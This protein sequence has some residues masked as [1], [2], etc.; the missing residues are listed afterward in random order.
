MNGFAWTTSFIIMVLSMV[1]VSKIGVVNLSW[2]ELSCL[3]LKKFSYA[4]ECQ[5]NDNQSY[6]LWNIRA[7]R[8]ILSCLVGASLAYCGAS[9]QGFFRNSLADPGIIGIT[10]GATLAASTAIVVFSLLI[11]NIPAFI[12][13]YS[14]SFAAFIG[15]ALATMIVM[16]ISHSKRGTQIAI[17]LLSGIAI[18]ALA[19]AISGILVYVADDVQLRSIT[20]W[21]LGSIAGASWQIVG[22]VAIGLAIAIILIT[23]MSKALNAIALGEKEMEYLGFSFKEVKYKVIIGTALATGTAVAFCGA[24]GFVGLV[25]PH[26]IRVAGI[27]N[28]KT[29]MPLS[30]LFGG[31]LLIWADTISRTIV[32]PSELPI[33]IITSLLG[34]PVFLFLLLRQKRQI[35]L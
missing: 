27:E 3:F 16:A 4:T 2:Q 5:V 6:I 23:P 24:I 32:L 34:A 17:L 12:K 19:G 31:I 28:Y 13:D 11:D 7:P 29:L 25:V 30:A 1:Y 18:N 9:L 10:G 33:G 26:I 22:I 20:F 21:V 15:A 35:A 14:I 8:I